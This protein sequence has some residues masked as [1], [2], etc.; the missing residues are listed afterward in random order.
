MRP[1]EEDGISSSILRFL[2]IASYW[3]LFLG[4]GGRKL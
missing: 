2:P 4:R 1:E 3:G